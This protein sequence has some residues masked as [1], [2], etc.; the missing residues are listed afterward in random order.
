MTATPA[1]R[2]RRPPARSPERPVPTGP[3]EGRAPAPGRPEQQPAPG[4]WQERTGP[5]SGGWPEQQPAP[6]GWPEQQPG[7]SSGGSRRR[8]APEDGPRERPAAGRSRERRSPARPARSP[9]PPKPPKRRGSARAEEW[10]IPWLEERGLTRGQQKLVV[11]G[12]SVIAA[13]AAL[14]VFMLVVSGLGGGSVPERAET[15]AAGTQPRP[16][17]YKGWVSSKVFAPIAQRTADPEPLALKDVF[18]EKTLKEGRITLKLAG[19]KLDS[20]CAA[21]V[22][23]PAL[24]D[25]LTQAGCTQALRGLYTS[26][27]GRYVAQYTLFNLRDTA[28]ADALVTALTTMHRG[29]WALALD[30]GTAAFPAGGHTE[31]SGHAMGHY[32]GLVWI[33]R[34]DGAEPDVKDDFVSLA[35]TARRPE[36]A[37]FRR[38]VAVAP[39]PPVP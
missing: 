11:A 23:G 7:S 10:S 12:G 27:D 30:S 34:A 3:Q 39:K 21:A 29:G 13:V 1:R 5:A 19:S 35:L 28:S 4:G 25:R 8:A 15:S 26:A 38:V 2:R 6:G 32:A 22:W 20:G 17:A 31:A 14:T 18:A 36:K 9:K 16:G 33:G 24:A 37:V